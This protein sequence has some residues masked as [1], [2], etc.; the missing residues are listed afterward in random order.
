MVGMGALPVAR[1]R[2]LVAAAAALYRR[3]GTPDG[4]ARHVE[5][6]LGR[7]TAVLE[8]YRLRRW[9]VVDQARLG[10]AT[11]LF[12]RDVVQRLR[13][14]G[15]SSIGAFRLVSTPSPQLDP[16]AVYAHRFTLLVRAR[17]G[18]DVE[19]LAAT[20]A[21][22]LAAVRPA[23]TLSSVSVV[24]PTARVEEQATLGLD[25]VVAGPPPAGRLGDRLGIVLARDPRRS[26]L[27]SIGIDARVGTR[28]G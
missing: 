1:R 19:R 23:H 15:G 21:R 10:D 8:H 22:V 14:D 18:D 5:L 4:V 17:P 28:A 13:L 3:R 26:D 27:R 25:A 20:A 12:G 9:A 7:P 2:R 24:T 16:F 6:W 11:R